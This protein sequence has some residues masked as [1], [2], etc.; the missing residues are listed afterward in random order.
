MGSYEL[1]FYRPANVTVKRV[2]DV[3]ELRATIANGGGRVFLFQS[4]LRPPLWMAQNRIGCT[5]V[6]RTLPSW[7]SR[8]NVNNWTSRI[9]V[10]T[11]FSLSTSASGG[12]CQPSRTLRSCQRILMCPCMTDSHERA[13]ISVRTAVRRPG[14]GTETWLLSTFV[15]AVPP[16]LCDQ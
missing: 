1:N 10:W 6:V 8:V 5:P 13:E 11:V 3:E 7:V 2:G 16:G 12:G 4:S 9:C 15:T 14:I